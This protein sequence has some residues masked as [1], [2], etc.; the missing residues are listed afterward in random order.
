MD[1]GITEQVA[2]GDVSARSDARWKLATAT[3][4]RTR[5]FKYLAG[6]MRIA[7]RKTPQEEARQKRVRFLTVFAVLAA[8][9]L[10]LLIF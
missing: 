5:L 2:E 1:K 6:G 4:V 9:W 3:V 10:L 8:M 7:G